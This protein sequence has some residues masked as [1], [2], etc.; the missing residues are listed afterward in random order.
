M[1]KCPKL[2]KIPE[3]NS[4]KQNLPEQKSLEQKLFGQ[5]PL[6]QGM[7]KYLRKFREYLLGEMIYYPPPWVVLLLLLENDLDE[8][9]IRDILFIS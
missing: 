8:L 3:Q 6:E 5:N 2:R 1:A 9:V 4:L 7:L